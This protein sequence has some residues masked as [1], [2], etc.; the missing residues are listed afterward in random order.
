MFP[1]LKYI[2]SIT[3]S[4]KLEA[5]IEAH[6]LF[7]GKISHHVDL[8]RNLHNKSRVMYKHIQFIMFIFLQ[9]DMIFFPRS[10]ANKIK[11]HFLR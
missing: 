8:K 6:V 7:N 2:L 9:K 10:L 1:Q 3:K 4:A 5:E 11:L